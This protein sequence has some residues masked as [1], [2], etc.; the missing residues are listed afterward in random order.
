[1]LCVRPLIALKH[2]L[3]ANVV[4]SLGRSIDVG[5]DQR[6]VSPSAIDLPAIGSQSSRMAGWEQVAAADTD[7]RTDDVDR[8]REMPGREYNDHCSQLA[9]CSVFVNVYGR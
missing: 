8:T 6:H 9:T 1:V 4:D 3:D 5:L 2:R 7:A